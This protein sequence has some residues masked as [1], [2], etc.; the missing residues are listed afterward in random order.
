V[1]WLQWHRVLSDPGGKLF[2]RNL[3]RREL[4]KG[5]DR[6]VVTCG[7]KHSI[8]HQEEFHCDKCSP[9]VSVQKRMIS[10]NAVGLGCG[11]QGNI[12]FSVLG[13]ELRP[14]QGGFKQPLVTDA[15][16]PSMLSKLCRMNAQNRRLGDPT[17]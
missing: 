10:R 3:A 15:G 13:L 8:F 12:S 9:L 5:Q 1:S 14:R 16:N 7:Q 4:Q 17:V 11:Q 2:F 6:I